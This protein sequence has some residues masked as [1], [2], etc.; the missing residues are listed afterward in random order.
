[1]I[2]YKKK[3]ITFHYWTAFLIMSI[4]IDSGTT[5][6]QAEITIV[7]DEGC[8]SHHGGVIFYIN[9]FYPFFVFM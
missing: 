8:Y 7:P 6:K 3:I 1:M 4:H 2:T 5:I 9:S